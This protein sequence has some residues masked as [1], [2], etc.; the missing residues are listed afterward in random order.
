M[1]D[2]N[3]ASFS[4]LESPPP[5]YAFILFNILLLSLTGVTV[6]WVAQ[7]LRA[8]TQALYFTAPPPVPNGIGSKKGLGVFVWKFG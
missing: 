4:D 7:P 3:T 8:I 1:L 5:A 2:S 6:V